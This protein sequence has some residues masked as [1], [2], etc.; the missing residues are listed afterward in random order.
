MKVVAL[1]FSAFVATVSMVYGNG[2]QAVCPARS[3]PCMNDKN[4]ARCQRLIKSG[5]LQI[6][7]FESCPLQF[8]CAKR[9][10]TLRAP[11]R[12][13]PVAAAAPTRPVAPPVR[14]PKT[15]TTT[16]VRAPPTRKI[17]DPCPPRT[18]ECLTDDL[19]QQCQGLVQQGCTSVIAAL[20]CPYAGFGCAH[21]LHVGQQPSP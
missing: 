5:C 9:V 12:P 1:F 21:E 13:V 19:F 15:P 3:A 16:I 4:F 18:D 17:P 7:V 6:N 2:Q 10:P 20:S 14:S 11:A 8:S